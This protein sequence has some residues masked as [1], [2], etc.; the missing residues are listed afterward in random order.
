MYSILIIIITI[1]MFLKGWACFLFFDPQYEVDPSTYYTKTLK[2][3][4][5]T[6]SV[7]GK[8]FK[9]NKPPG[10]QSVNKKS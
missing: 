2:L 4:S 5:K 7:K 10:V 9:I 8:F 3:F 1:I 6:A